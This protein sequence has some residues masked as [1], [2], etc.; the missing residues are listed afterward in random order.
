MANKVNLASFVKK[1]Q[2]VMNKPA[3]RL[4]KTV[5]LG[6]FDEAVILE[7]VIEEELVSID[8]KLPPA[9][10]DRKLVYFGC[11]TIR[12]AAGKMLELQAIDDPMDIFK[13]ISRADMAAMA[14]IVGELTTQAM[15]PTVKEIEEIKN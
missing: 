15:Q 10:Q 7:S 1:L 14:K 6:S 3:K 13:A 2:R 12:E 5:E 4:S 9:E 8:E 11:P